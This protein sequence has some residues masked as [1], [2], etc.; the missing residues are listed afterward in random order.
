MTAPVLSKIFD[1]FFTTKEI[2][3]GTGLG[4]AVV[5]G[6]VQQHKGWVSVYSEVG[7]GTTFRI[8]IPRLHKEGESKSA[9]AVWAPVRGG[10]ETIL[11]VEDDAY[12]RA[13]THKALSN[14]G[15]R[16]L[17]ASNGPEAQ[18]VWKKHRNEVHFAQKLW[19]EQRDEIRLLLTDLIMPGGITGKDLGEKLLAEDPRLKVI[20][21]S[22][23]SAE[24]A[25]KHFTLHEGVN[26]V[27]KPFQLHSLLQTVRAR[28]D[29]PS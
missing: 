8:F 20:Y 4:L 28:L 5:H 17:E 18:E 22:G 19:K 15:Y 6:V 3:K 9:P 29:E 16:V 23:Y 13:S 10:S 27:A 11:F 26:F 1:P 2:G 7:Y 14:A 25:G 24:V 21:M 12:L